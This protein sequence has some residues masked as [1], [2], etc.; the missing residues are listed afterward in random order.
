[1][2]K[3]H[4]L[5]AKLQVL[6]CQCSICFCAVP[7]LQRSAI[8]V[9]DKCVCVCVFT[10]AKQDESIEMVKEGGGRASVSWR[11]ASSLVV[12]RACIERMLIPP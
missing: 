8:K 2:C 12:S 5:L 11:C 1:M 3:I 4:L 10:L 6:T 9:V 7:L